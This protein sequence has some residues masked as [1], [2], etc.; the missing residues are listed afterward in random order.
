MGMIG[1][2]MS[3]VWGRQPASNIP[4][5]LLT[6]Y[7]VTSGGMTV[8]PPSAKW[9]WTEPALM[10]LALTLGLFQWG[11]GFKAIASPHGAI[12]GIPAPAFFIFGSIALSAAFGDFR[13]ARAGGAGA[14]RGAPRL[15][16]HL[17]RMSV[18]L[19][20][21][22]FSFFLG[23]T[24]VIP[25]PIRIIPLLV[26]PPLLALGAMLYWLWRVRRRRSS[27]GIVV[28]ASVAPEQLAR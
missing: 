9:R 4:M 2:A 19:V 3:A 27:R 20:I 26:T 21:A 1:A 5:G 17:W 15:S 8:R 24:Q 16:R 13:L 6:A 10:T 18:A 7:L 28:A 12:A 11:F 25:K 22:A 23:Q 14:I